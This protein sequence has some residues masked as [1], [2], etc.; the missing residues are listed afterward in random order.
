M[1]SFFSNQSTNAA[2]CKLIP[3]GSGP[4][5]C[6]SATNTKA[7]TSSGEFSCAAGHYLVRGSTASDPDYCVRMCLQVS[8]M[9]CGLVVRVWVN[10]CHFRRFL[11]QPYHYWLRR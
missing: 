4:V 10:D 1:T 5:V 7:D 11:K 3:N 8:W 9:A 6:T 2:A